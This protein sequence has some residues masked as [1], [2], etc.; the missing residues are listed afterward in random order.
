MTSEPIDGSEDAKVVPLRAVDAGTE[1]RT[2]EAA[3]PAYT[4]LSDGRAQ[5]QAHHPRALAHLGR[6]PR[7]CAA[8]RRPARARRRLP[9]HPRTRLPRR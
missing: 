3:G 7:A 1:T 6:G 9:R 2:S 8:G 4:D 5:P